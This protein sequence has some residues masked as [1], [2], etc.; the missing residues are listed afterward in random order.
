MWLSHCFKF[1]E[2]ST[3]GG[4]SRQQQ[5]T[6]NWRRWEENYC[7]TDSLATTCTRTERCPWQR[8][9]R[10]CIYVWN[11]TARPDRRTK[12]RNCFGKFVA[13]R[14]CCVC[15]CCRCCRC[16]PNRLRAPESWYCVLLAITIHLHLHYHSLVLFFRW[17]FA[18]PR[19]VAGIASSSSAEAAAAAA[20]S[21]STS[22]SDDAFV[23]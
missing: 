17:F 2:T 7:S 21:S 1:R 4:S 22:R 15:H 5:W 18:I 13:P 16:C 14:Y 8:F 6:M 9:R 11:H 23:Q 12:R 20:G 19:T 10:L 3:I